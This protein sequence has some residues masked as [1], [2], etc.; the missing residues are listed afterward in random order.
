MKLLVFDFDGTIA[1]SKNAYYSVIKRELGNF[2]FSEK[3]VEKAID[4]G[5][6]LRKTLGNL[7]LNFLVRWYLHARIMSQVKKYV[8]NIKRCHDVAS[9]KKIKEKKIV[10][11]N[12]V[13]E[14]ALK[15]L[16]HLKI[17]YFDEVY[18]AD[19]FSDKTDFI[20]EYLRKNNIN[21]KDCYYIGDRAADTKLAKDVGCKSIIISNSCSWNNKSQLIKSHPTFLISDL[22]KIKDIVEK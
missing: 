13:D 5:M 3:E 19:D 11:T 12:S 21:K 2:G 6:S 14:F 10:V 22:S 4:I 9:I 20:R 15:V 8:K 7:G 18:G 16:K 17:N 1:D